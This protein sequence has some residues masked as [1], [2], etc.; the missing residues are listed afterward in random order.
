[1]V[2]LAGLLRL[3]F[4]E[5]RHLYTP[6]AFESTAAAPATLASRL[7]EGPTWLAT[8]GED[9]AGTLSCRV[10]GGACHLR[11]GSERDLGGT[12]VVAM[13][14]PIPRSLG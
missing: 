5:Y 4:E 8:I 7:D 2:A 11:R 10:S 3:S 14:K 13:A 6:P 9:L 1:M 12:T